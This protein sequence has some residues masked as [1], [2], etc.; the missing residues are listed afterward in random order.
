MKP[1]L[2]NAKIHIQY[3]LDHI[4]RADAILQNYNHTHG[5]LDRV[6]EDVRADV[7]DA[8]DTLRQAR[9]TIAR[10]IINHQANPN[11]ADKLQLAKDAAEMNAGTI[12]DRK[13]GGR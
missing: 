5:G 13:V 6:D 12:L 8:E 4:L 7:F 2:R 10:A 9:H 11:H 3:A 1:N